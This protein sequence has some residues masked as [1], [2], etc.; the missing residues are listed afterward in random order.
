MLNILKYCI[1]EEKEKRLHV[2]IISGL[3]LR[4]LLRGTNV[5]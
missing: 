3:D 2:K 1:Y 4:Q 5:I